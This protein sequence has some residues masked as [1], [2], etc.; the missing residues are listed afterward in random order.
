MR[1]RRIG[2]GYA[3]HRSFRRGQC[4]RRRPPPAA[5]MHT[6]SHSCTNA[7]T[8]V[9]MPLGSHAHACIHAHACRGVKSSR[10]GL[11]R[12][13]TPTTGRRCSKPSSN[14][15]ITVFFFTQ[16]IVG[17]LSV[18]LLGSPLRC[19]CHARQPDSSATPSGLGV[20]GQAVLEAGSRV[21]LFGLKNEALNGN[22]ATV[23]RNQ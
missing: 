9:R 16:I 10:T 18:P 8:R 19:R 21:M 1:I 2:A 17:D 20:S 7:R 23:K 3:G 15:N 12:R 5:R 13:P 11:R 6:C 4:A 14:A 22:A